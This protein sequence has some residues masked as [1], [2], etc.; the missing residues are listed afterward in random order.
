MLRATLA[1]AG[2]A[3]VLACCEAACA[4]TPAPS[5]E[6]LYIDA[7]E[8]SSSGGHVAL[9]I[10]DRVYHFQRDA[11]GALGLRRE[12]W[13]GFA[14]QYRVTENRTLSA[15][16][17]EIAEERMEGLRHRL[18]REVML[19]EA[20]SRTLRALRRDVALLEVLAGPPGERELEMRGAGFFA[21]GR[22]ATTPLERAGT[23]TIWPFS[24]TMRRGDMGL[25]AFEDD[26]FNEQSSDRQVDRPPGAPRARV[27]R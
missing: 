26:P 21:R 20:E 15:T 11:S 9:R 24:T 17:L 19:E 25:A 27:T 13:A 5:V 12:T 16:R 4:E 22:D 1:L 18:D 6:Y 10:G 7:N 8:G 2:I 23:F 14:F 3:L